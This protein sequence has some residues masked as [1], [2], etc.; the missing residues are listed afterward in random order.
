MSLPNIITL[1]RILLVPLVVWAIA[2]GEPLIAFWLFLAAGIS[3]ALD[4]FIA[5]RF[6]LQTELGSYLDPVADKALLISIYVSLAVAGLI[7]RW[8]AIA[9]VSRDVMI[10]GA[11]V[12]SLVM[13]K[14]VAMSPL[15]VSK[16]NTAIQ[17]A[18]AA[19]VLASSGFGLAL[20]GLFQLGLVLVG[21]L[22]GLSAAAYLA[23]WTRHMAS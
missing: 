9:V 3:D 4:G 10:I 7:P 15:L 13:A 16:V 14:P 19:F 23:A 20:P 1:I 17:I 22:T 21:V 11:V 8:V 18:F 12:L 5:K 6:H 2:S